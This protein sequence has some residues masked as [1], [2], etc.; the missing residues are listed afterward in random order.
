M[1]E[2]S[3]FLGWGISEINDVVEYERMKAGK[4]Y[5]I[6]QDPPVDANLEAWCSMEGH[7]QP[8]DKRTDR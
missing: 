2:A 7:T 6:N 4:S 1:L 3:T 8:G 5:C